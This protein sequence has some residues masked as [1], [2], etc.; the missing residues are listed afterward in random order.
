MFKATASCWFEYVLVIC[1][2]AK[3]DLIL[4]INVLEHL[5]YEDGLKVLEQSL[6]TGSNVLISTPKDIGDQGAGYGN[7]YETHHFQWKKST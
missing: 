4:R 1:Q 7:V 2:N 5:S 6:A 3:Y